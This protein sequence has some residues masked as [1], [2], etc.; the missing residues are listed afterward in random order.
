MQISPYLFFN[1]NCAEAF[2]F[3]EKC[4]GGK[5]KFLMTYGES[6]EAAKIPAEMHNKVIHASLQVGEH[7]FSGSDDCSAD[8]FK[9]PQGFSVSISTKDPEEAKRIFHALSENG[10]VT[11]AID[12]T[13][14]S[15]A[16]GMLVDQYGI[17]WMVNTEGQA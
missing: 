10:T 15:P 6:P 1:G 14:W 8:G 4:L 9:R 11:L 7:V 12:K 3:Y 13:F 2:R 5:I 17:P 16:F